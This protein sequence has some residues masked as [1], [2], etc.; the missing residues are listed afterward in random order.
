MQEQNSDQLERPK[1]VR[2]THSKAFKAQ[3][4]AQANTG[5][6]SVAKLAMEYLYLLLL[7]RQLHHVMA[8]APW[9]WK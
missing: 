4:V 5:D 3:L 7:I 1:R 6:V 9:S 2:R 8:L